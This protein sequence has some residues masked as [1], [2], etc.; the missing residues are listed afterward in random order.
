MKHHT[1]MCDLSVVWADKNVDSW[2]RG[3]KVTYVEG[4]GVIH[5]QVASYSSYVAPPK[6]G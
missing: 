1:P 3:Y 2:G 4:R 5:H 6:Q